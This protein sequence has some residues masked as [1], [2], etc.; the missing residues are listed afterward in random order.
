MNVKLIKAYLT[1]PGKSPASIAN[2]RL[3]SDKKVSKKVSSLL[4]S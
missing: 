1:E 2:I 4:I 3:T